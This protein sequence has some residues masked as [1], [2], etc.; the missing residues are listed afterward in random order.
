M[1]AEGFSIL[2]LILLCVDRVEVILCGSLVSLRGSRVT[3]LWPHFEPRQLLTFGFDVDQNL[4]F[5]LD[6][7]PAFHANADL[8]A[9]PD[10]ASQK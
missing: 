2:L 8:N 4:A 6:T 9:D 5:D 1:F 10:P 7:E 3:P